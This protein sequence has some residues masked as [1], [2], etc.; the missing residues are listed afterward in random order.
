MGHVKPGSAPRSDRPEDVRAHKDDLPWFI[1][2]FVKV[3]FPIPV[4]PTLKEYMWVAIKRV[5]NGVL[6]GTLANISVRGVAAFGAPVELTFD[7]IHDV[8]DSSD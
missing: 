5:E 7:E 2:R 3:G 4:D 8:C 1:G 6:Q